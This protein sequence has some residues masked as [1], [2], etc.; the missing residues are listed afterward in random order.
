CGTGR[1][2]IPLARAGVDVTGTDFSKPYLAEAR[3]AARR[4]KVKANFVRADM[5]R[6]PFVDRFDAAYCLWTSFSYFPR[7]ADDLRTLRGMRRALVPG[8]RLLIDTYN[9]PMFVWRFHLQEVLGLAPATWT[10]LEDGTF[11]LEDPELSADEKSF[12]SRWIFLKGTRRKE[13]VSFTRNYD[14]ARLKGVMRRAGFK[15]LR[16]YGS[17]AAAPYHLLRAP[18]VVVLA[19]RPKR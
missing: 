17:L 11:I 10:L 1:H 9:G 7:V 6:L 13:M 16:V 15:I 8:G 18:R 14:A 19:E 5:R 4:A 3:R 12:S 2:A